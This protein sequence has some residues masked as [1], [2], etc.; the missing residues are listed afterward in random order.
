VFTFDRMDAEVVQHVPVL[1]ETWV[2]SFRGRLESILDEEDQV[3][4]FMLPSLGSGSTLRGFSSF[5]FRDRH[6]LLL[7]AE[8]RW[9]PN[10]YGFDMA[11]FVDSGKVTARRAD[12]DL[13][14]LKTDFGIGVRL[15][16]PTFTP[17]R[18]EL[19]R[20]NERLKLVFS[21]SAAF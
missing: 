3:P 19:A 5:R 7:Q 1:H 10:R 4:F 18:V 16:G 15:H 17:L 2:L 21:G 8:F 11:L 9:F 14:G 6:S 20:S 13:D 12:L